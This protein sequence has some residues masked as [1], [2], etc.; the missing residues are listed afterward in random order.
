MSCAPHLDG[1]VRRV[2]LDELDDLLATSD[3]PVI[4]D[5]WAA[6]CDDCRVVSPI[7]EEI[8]RA[9]PDDV[10]VVAVDVEAD[11]AAAARHHVVRLPAVVAFRGGVA[12]RAVT[13][14]PTRAELDE[15]LGLVVTP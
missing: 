8:A 15:G 3:V 1:P 4:V 13:G 2:D 5:F 7:V 12:D 9:R 14:T 10:V 11:P 6:W